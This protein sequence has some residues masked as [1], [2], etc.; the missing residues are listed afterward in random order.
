LAAQTHFL[1]AAAP[2]APAAQSLGLASGVDAQL[3][4]CSF[5]DTFSSNPQRISLA[6]TYHAPK[7]LRFHHY[8]ALKN[9]RGS[10]PFSL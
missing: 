9:L 1:E 2:P 10:W 6:F 8:V 3:S 4:A 5:G 7:K